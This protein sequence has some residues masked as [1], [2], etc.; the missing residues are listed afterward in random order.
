MNNNKYVNKQIKL[1]KNKNNPKINVKHQLFRKIKIP[2]R[3]ILK[4]MI[5]KYLKKNIQ[6]KQN[7][8][9]IN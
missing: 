5:F 9:L 7:L 8:L 1:L 6:L 4:K 2:Y 3:Q